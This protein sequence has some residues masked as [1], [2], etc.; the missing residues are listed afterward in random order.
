MNALAVYCG[1]S[2]G[3]GT[4]YVSLARE[5]GREMARRGIT[6]VYGGGS[7]GLMGAVADAALAGGGKVIGVIPHFL[8]TRELAHS[9]CTELIVVNSMHERKAVMAS[10]CEGFVALPGGFGTLDEIFEA[11][12]WSQLGLHPWPCGLLDTDGYFAPLVQCLD[13]M[14]HRGFLRPEDRGRLLHAQAFSELLE[15][16]AAWR[17]PDGLKWQ[18]LPT[19][20]AAKRALEFS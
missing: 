14:V 19:L 17:V 11:L 16:M 5:V 8:N 15:N 9:A 4:T 20:E 18:D 7:V 2:A 10:L 3:S 12:T 1:S 6:L 13:G